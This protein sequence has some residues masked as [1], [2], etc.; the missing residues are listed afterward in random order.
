[1]L[2]RSMLL[3]RIVHLGPLDDYTFDYLVHDWLEADWQSCVVSWFWKHDCVCVFLIQ[4]MVAILITE[5]F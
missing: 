1:M 3:F 5:I 2:P 4:D